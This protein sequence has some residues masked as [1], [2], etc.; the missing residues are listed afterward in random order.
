V[1]DTRDLT[2][3]N[4]RPP[5]APAHSC[6]PRSG[7]IRDPGVWQRVAPSRCRP[8]STASVSPTRPHPPRG[9][10]SGSRR[11]K[12][13]DARSRFSSRR[14]R[15]FR[16]GRS[17]RCRICPACARPTTP[18]IRT[19]KALVAVMAAEMTPGAGGH[20]RVSVQDAAGDSSYLI[21]LAIGDLA[22]SPMSARTA[23]GRPSIGGH[24]AREFEDTEKMIRGHRGRL[25]PDRWGRYDL[26]VLP[27]SSRFGGMENPRLTFATPTVIA[28][29]QSLVSLVAHELAHSCPGI[30]HHATWP[31]FWLNE[32]F[33]S[34]SS[35]A[36][37][38][39]STATAGGDGGHD[40]VCAELEES[41]DAGDSPRQDAA[42]EW[43]AAFRTM[44]IRRCHTNRVP[45]CPGVPR[46]QVRARGV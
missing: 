6:R 44:P 38:R 14:R 24:A 3:Q 7:W 42:P 16:R 34:T 17:S 39:R 18:P 33:T 36:S 45:C 35:V 29:G 46:G 5:S 19:P 20:G 31:D 37:S 40:P 25:W 10:C 22:F 2:I 23:Y 4:A 26:L 21:A 32:R 27:P 12:P 41:A 8:A 43:P 9:D 28:G 1:L 13:P 30:S 11:R 15:R